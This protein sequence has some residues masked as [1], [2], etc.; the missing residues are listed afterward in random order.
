[1]LF[2]PVI[3]RSSKISLEHSEAEKE[4]EVTVFESDL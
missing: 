2:A 4:K 1:M 3:Q